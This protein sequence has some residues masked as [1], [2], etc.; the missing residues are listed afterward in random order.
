MFLK[1]IKIVIE[2][3]YDHLSCDSF[4]ILKKISSMS[5]YRLIPPK[6][7][8]NFLDLGFNPTNLTCKVRTPQ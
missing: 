5:T 2:I 6:H 7:I 8:T 3:L 1:S 4:N